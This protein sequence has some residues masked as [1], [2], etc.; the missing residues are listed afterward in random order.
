MRNKLIKLL[1]SF[2][3]EGGFQN[4]YADGFGKEQCDYEV[5]EHLDFPNYRVVI[6]RY[7]R[8]YP[9]PK[10]RGLSPSVSGGSIKAELKRME[11]D[12]LLMIS[13]QKAVK[14][15]YIDNK[16]PDPDYDEGFMFTSESIIL[17]TKGKSKLR[18]V[19]YKATENPIPIVFSLIATIISIISLFL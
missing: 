10:Y 14:Y 18:Y 5:E 3:K 2:E 1:R 4:L 9:L 12:G 17:T 16:N 6:S 8:K 7:N 11:M 15:A 13:T 19:I